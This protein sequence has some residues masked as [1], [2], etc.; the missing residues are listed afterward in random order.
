MNLNESSL[1]HPRTLWS[2]EAAMWRAIE[3]KACIGRAEVCSAS[4]KNLVTVIHQRGTVGAF[5][6]YIGEENVTGQMLSFL[7]SNR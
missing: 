6:F 7:R 1:R 3:H 4:G 2:I 5:R